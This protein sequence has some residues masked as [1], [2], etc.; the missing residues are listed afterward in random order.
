MLPAAIL[1]KYSTLL[2]SALCAVFCAQVCWMFLAPVSGINKSGFHN[3]KASEKA[4]SSPTTSAKTITTANLFGKE[5][6]TQKPQAT[7]PKKITKLKIKV[8][9]I[10]SSRDKQ[11]I[12]IIKYKGKISSILEGNSLDEFGDDSITL[13]KIEDSQITI[14]NS[15][16]DEILPLDRSMNKS[17]GLTPLENLNAPPSNELSFDLKSNARIQNILDKLD[18]NLSLKPNYLK[19]FIALQEISSPD[20]DGYKVFSGVDRSLLSLTPLKPGDV[21]TH[22]NQLQAKSYTQRQLLDL[23]KSSPLLTVRL[24]RDSEALTFKI[25]I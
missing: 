12:A 23:L 17:I 3:S 9:G 19:R 4:P 25:E 1:S 5:A 8:I 18:S 24:K 20:I 11:N 14:N 22:I 7:A 15:G 10:I 21:I 16:S 13:S 2:L 6:I